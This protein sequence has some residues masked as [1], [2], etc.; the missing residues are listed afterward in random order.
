MM[1]TLYGNCQVEVLGR[2]MRMRF[3]DL[4]VH[5]GGNSERVDAYDPER[6]AALMDR[7]D[8]VVSQPIMN[9]DHPDR[10]D[11]L[12]G[13]LGDKLIF[14]PYIFADG[15]FALSDAPMRPNPKVSTII[16]EGAL[17]TRLQADGYRATSR[18]LRSGR[19]AFNH[20][21]R[22]RQN[23]I[24]MERREELCDIRVLDYI[25]AHYRTRPLM[26]THNHPMPE[27]VN[28]CARQLAARIGREY[29]PISGRE[30][31]RMASITLARTPNLCHPSTCEELG[32]T[33]APDLHW[34][35]TGEAL[36][37]RI[38]TAL[39]VPLES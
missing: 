2:A 3:P 10:H 20:Q 1:I 34:A 36:L 28:E 17:I 19:I 21:A 8:L 23:L 30:P 27:L 33:Y 9:P 14:V 35:D 25:R 12:R 32:L 11:L 37:R 24:E 29:S 15:L 22:L 7:S 4:E 39:K 13:R 5:Y 6:T 31:Y 16:N 26:I 18:D 38:A